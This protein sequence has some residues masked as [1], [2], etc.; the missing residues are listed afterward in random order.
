MEG[1][2]G[3]V[4]GVRRGFGRLLFKERLPMRAA[5]I[6]MSAANAVSSTAGGTSRDAPDPT[7]DPTMPSAPKARPCPSRTLPRRACGDEG[8]E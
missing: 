1:D 4:G 3:F 5:T 6:S 2:Q 8:D 7:N